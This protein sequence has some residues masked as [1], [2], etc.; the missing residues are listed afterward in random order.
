MNCRSPNTY[1]RPPTRLP[2]AR[3]MPYVG[4]LSQS[5]RS[6]LRAV[7]NSKLLYASPTWAVRGTKTAKNCSEMA[8]AQ[9]T[10]A[11]RTVRAYRTVS[12]DASS[13]L[14]STL[15]ADLL[16][17]ERARIR[18]RLDD[19]TDDASATAVKKEERA[20]SIGAWQARWDRSLCGRRTH[21]L[22]P[23]VG[24]WLVRRTGWRKRSR[25]TDASR[26]TCSNINGQSTH[27]ACTARRPRPLDRDS[28]K[29]SEG[30]RRRGNPVWTPV[31]GLARR[32]P[33]SFETN[34]LVRNKSL[35]VHAYGRVNPVDQRGRRTGWPGIRKSTRNRESCM[36]VTASRTRR[37]QIWRTSRTLTSMP[38][39]KSEVSPTSL[40]FPTDDT[41][42]GNDHTR[43]ARRPTNEKRETLVG[44]RNRTGTRLPGWRTPVGPR[45]HQEEF[46]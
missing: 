27:T 8:R 17:T 36:T 38:S 20:I 32:C 19:Q 15:S 31:R 46:R 4:G 29:T 35:G 45:R 39:E 13:I 37:A 9:R 25:G 30:G 10:V 40:S 2:N 43:I 6:L 21:R 11:L 24:R 26:A 22:V 42:G 7:A 23:D 41:V 3:L 14:D 12:A 34:R 18:Q 16:A 28:E 33:G 44:S 1:T 5:K